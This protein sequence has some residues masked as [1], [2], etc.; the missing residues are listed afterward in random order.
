MEPFQH[1]FL[2]RGDP[3]DT[4]VFKGVDDSSIGF[5]V[6]RNRLTIPHKTVPQGNRDPA[7]IVGHIPSG[8]KRT[9]IMPMACPHCQACSTRTVLPSGA[10]TSVG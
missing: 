5:A 3:N 4:A 2:F 8:E 7:L 1:A 6:R 10:F 9:R